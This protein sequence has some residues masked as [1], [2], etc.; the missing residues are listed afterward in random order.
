MQSQSKAYLLTGLVILFWGTAA[1]AFKIALRQV[2]P[3]TLLL[4]SVA[5]SAATLLVILIVQGKLSQL[6]NVPGYVL[7][8]NLLLGIVNPFLYYVVLFKA[9]SLLPGQIAMSLNYAWPLALTLLSV[10]ILGQ[11]LSRSQLVAVAI[12]FTGAILIATH[13]QFTNFGDLNRPGLFLAGGSAL[14]WASF[15]LLNAKDG[16]DPVLKLFLGFVS[17][18]LCTLLFSPLLG[19]IHLPPAAAWP[20]LVYV[21]LFE[22]GITFVLW[23]SA[24]QLSA[25]AARVGNLIYITPFLSL[26]F[27]RLIIHEQ[28]YPAT[29]LGLA[30]IVSSLI[31]QEY[32]AK[33]KPLR[34]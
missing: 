28:I 27:L 21:G 12:S 5:V 4:W 31:F 19:G 20:A 10:P 23:L 17:G 13:G 18:L 8:K 2:T 15:W 34:A 25:T 3:Y 22:M 1:S 6:R 11:K 14:I 33:R 30:L 29:C 7:R 32:H 24:L 16:L 9:Y 26:L